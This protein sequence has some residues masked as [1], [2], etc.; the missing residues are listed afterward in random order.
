MRLKAREKECSEFVIQ[1]VRANNLRAIALYEGMGAT[2]V[3]TSDDLSS[4][5]ISPP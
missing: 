3:Q 4:F 5:V 2:R 1:G